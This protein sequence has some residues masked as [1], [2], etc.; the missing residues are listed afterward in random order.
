MKLHACCQQLHDA[1]LNT[2]MFSLPKTCH[3]WCGMVLANDGIDCI[4]LWMD[5]IGYRCDN[6]ICQKYI[7]ESFQYM[8]GGRLFSL[9]K[10]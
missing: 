10:M 9:K 2:P 7:E 4:L 1:V 8:R 5:E 3:L 6:R